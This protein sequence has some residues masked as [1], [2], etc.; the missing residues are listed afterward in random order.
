MLEDIRGEVVAEEKQPVTLRRNNYYLWLTYDGGNKKTRFPVNPEKITVR[1]GSKNKSVDIVGLGEVLIPQ[2]RPAVSI[3]FSSFFPAAQFQGT[4]VKKLQSPMGLVK[5]LLSWKNSKKP[6]QFY[7]TN[8]RIAMFCYIEKLD[9]WEEGGDIG[10]VRFDITLKEYRDVSIRKIEY[11]QLGNIV[12]PAREY[13]RVNN[14]VVPRTYTIQS[15]DTLYS[16]ARAFLGDG[17]K[18]MELLRLNQE[19]LKNPLLIEAGTVI[20]LP[21]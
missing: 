17:S 13:D 14:K 3:E 21:E 4:R 5:R 9:Y 19:I 10:T 8:T 7:I 18:Y 12:V 1:E 6:C 11:D 16:I 15:G 2:A 20:R